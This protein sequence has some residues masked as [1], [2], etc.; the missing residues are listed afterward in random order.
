M[1]RTATWS[2]FERVKERQ[3]AIGGCLPV[4]DK[5]LQSFRVEASDNGLWTITIDSSAVATVEGGC[6][7]DLE[8]LER[9]LREQ[10]ALKKERGTA[11]KWEEDYRATLVEKGRQALQ[12][13][14]GVLKALVEKAI[15]NEQVDAGS[16]ASSDT[17]GGIGSDGW[18]PQSSRRSSLSRSRQPSLDGT[19]QGNGTT[20]RTDPAPMS[21]KGCEVM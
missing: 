15:E 7:T 18:T 2:K 5:L 13:W 19:D 21:V 20:N 14:F 16:I 12:E 6:Q 8:S 4:D 10:H 3:A 1:F 17:L 9:W 11:G